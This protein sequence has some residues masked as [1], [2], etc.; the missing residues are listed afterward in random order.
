MQRQIVIIIIIIIITTTVSPTSG[1][2]IQQGG[3]SF[4]RLL[5]FVFVKILFYFISQPSQNAKYWIS[6]DLGTDN[7]QYF[8]HF[9]AVLI[10]NNREWTSDYNRPTIRCGRECVTDTSIDTPKLLASEAR[11][12]DEKRQRKNGAT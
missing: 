8:G 7:K 3:R 4:D 11:N 6:K 10:Q 2:D 5:T 9:P 12:T 1:V